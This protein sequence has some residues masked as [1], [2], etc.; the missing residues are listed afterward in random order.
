[1]ALC[2]AVA[3]GTTFG[4]TGTIRV[5]FYADL[6]GT[7]VIFLFSRAFDNSSLYDP[8][9]SLAPLP[10]AAYWMLVPATPHVPISRSLI[11]LAL[12]G[13]WGLR[14]TY[15][16]WRGWGGLEHEDW[17]YRDMRQKLGRFYWP[18]SF[19]GIHLL[20]TLLVFLGCLPL[21]AVFSSGIRPLSFL[22]LVAVAVT[23]LAIGWEAIADD[24]LK[25]FRRS[26]R[27]PERFLTAG[28]WAY[29]RHPNYLGEIGFWWG[30]V[31]FA[32]ASDPAYWWTGIGALAITVM[33]R[34]VS[35]RLIDDRML[36]SRPGYARHIRT[37]PAFFP[38][39]SRSSGAQD[40]TTESP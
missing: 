17:R 13:I 26:N 34:T 15:N 6:A 36:E 25:R 38:S 14:L 7:V 9:W 8:Y 23:G 10:I 18:G 32:V 35:L 21:Y 30:L 20:P 29:S 31:L 37:T 11:V 33:F 22:D 16:W 3:V 39:R 1:L 19:L 40:E 27:D 12:V 5:A 28:L 2:A 24:Q 4:W